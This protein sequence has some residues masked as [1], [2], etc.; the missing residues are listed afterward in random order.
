MSYKDRKLWIEPALH[1]WHGLK[2][3]I[4]QEVPPEIAL[5]E[6]DCRKPECSHGEHEVCE[7]RR[8]SLAMLESSA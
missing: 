6:F 7:R 5:C 8:K 3:Q 1:F 2:D 4:V